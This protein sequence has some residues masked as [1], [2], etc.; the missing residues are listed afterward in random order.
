MGGR[1]SSP[2]CS[3]L[4]CVAS[5]PSSTSGHAS[6]ELDKVTCSLHA[7]S[8]GG[9]GPTAS[10]QRALSANAVDGA[11]ASSRLQ[12]VRSDR[13]R[14]ELATGIMEDPVVVRARAV[15]ARR[16]SLPN[17]GH[18]VLSPARI[19]DESLRGFESEWPVRRRSLPVLPVDNDLSPTGRTRALESC[20]PGTV[21]AIQAQ[22]NWIQDKMDRVSEEDHALG[23]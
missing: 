3:S 17:I 4:S 11:D 6:L 7:M 18:V 13:T 1:T 9:K 20:S 19:L 12:R 21:A 5:T 22:Q 16:S 8:T 10:L 15:Y 23:I 14:R 2:P